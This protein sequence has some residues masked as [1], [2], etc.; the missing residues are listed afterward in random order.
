MFNLTKNIV[1]G[2]VI[3][4][5]CLI[6]GIIGGSL[7][8]N[9]ATDNTSISNEIV[10]I[11]EEYE[12]NKQVLIERQEDISEIEAHITETKNEITE[13]QNYINEKEGSIKTMKKNLNGAK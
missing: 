4:F 2:I 7:M 10:K 13:L 5:I 11:N 9:I 8:T 1:K 6:I 12:T 3:S